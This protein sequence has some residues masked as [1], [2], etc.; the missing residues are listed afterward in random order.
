MKGAKWKDKMQACG[1][2]TKIAGRVLKVYGKLSLSTALIC[3]FGFGMECQFY[4]GR[5]DLSVQK[6]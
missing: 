3:F 1:E 4:A 2:K 6:S 5:G